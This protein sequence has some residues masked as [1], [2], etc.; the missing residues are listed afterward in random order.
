M[1]CPKCETEMTAVIINGITF[2]KCEFCGMEE[3][4]L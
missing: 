1:N 3:Q 2:Y 4:T